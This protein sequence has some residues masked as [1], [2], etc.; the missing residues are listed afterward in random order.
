MTTKATNE[1]IAY[2]VDDDTSINMIYRTKACTI[3]PS[4]PNHFEILCAL[5]DKRYDD[6]EPLLNV[7]N[8]IETSTNG[9]IIFDGQ[10]FLY[11]GPSVKGKP[12]R[13]HAAICNRM[14]DLIESGHS[15]A[16]ILKFVDNMFTNPSPKSVEELYLFLDK[17]KLPITQDGCFLAYKRVNE[18][19]RDLYSN[20]IDNS[21]GKTV[22]EDRKKVDANRNNTC[23]RGLHFCSF[24][25]LS[26]FKGAH[27]IL[28]KINPRDVVSI[29]TDYNNSKGRCCRYV[30]VKEHEKGDAF[31]L[32]NG[33]NAKPLYT[34][35]GDHV[36]SPYYNVRDRRGR[37]V[38]QKDRNQYHNLRDNKGRF[39]KRLA[40]AI[41]PDTEPDLPYHNLRGNDG[42]FIKK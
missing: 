7:A 9:H 28:V 32:F 12:Q 42:R 30:V 11:N 17:N 3:S 18:N 37:F 23:S 40:N 24:G 39:V 6:I 29:P 20:K 22:K 13:L 8:S 1:N 36:Q 26:C 14:F 31:D 16:Y 21:I 35:S 38:S 10:E 15:A 2:I 19:W 25:Y 41:V 33:K 34:A 27:T 5:K 4:H